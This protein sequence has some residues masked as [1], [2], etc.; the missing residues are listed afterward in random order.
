MKKTILALG[1]LF[2]VPAMAQLPPHPPLPPPPPRPAPVPAPRPVVVP[3]V[4]FVAPPPLVV[5]E[6]GIQVVEDHDDEIFFVDNYYWM[7][8]GDHW[9]R[10]P[11]HRGG[12]VVVDGP[13]VPPALVRVPHGRYRRYK[14]NK[15]HGASPVRGHGASSVVV[16]PPGPGPKVKVKVKKH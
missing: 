3:Q 1:M 2:A 12:W 7:R 10:T 15:V 16:N 14:H 11:N 13:G 6:P 4:T 5:V 8:R 9:Y